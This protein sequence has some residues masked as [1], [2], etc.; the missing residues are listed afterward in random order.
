[1]IDGLTIH[2]A[3]MYASILVEGGVRRVDEIRK[4]RVSAALP[5]VSVDKCYKLLLPVPPIPSRTP[6]KKKNIRWASLR[7]LVEI[8]RLIAQNEFPYVL[9]VEEQR[10]FS[11]LVVE[12]RGHVIYLC[13]ESGVIYECGESL[14]PPLKVIERLDFFLNRMDRVT[15]ATDVF[16]VSGYKS[17]TRFGILLQG[18]DNAVDY[19]A[20]LT[21]L[22]GKTGLGGLKSRG[23]GKFTVHTAEL[24][25]IDMITEPRKPCGMVLLGSYMFTE[26]IDFTKSIVNK[27]V[28]AGYA[29]PVY[30]PHKLPY[31]DY[32][33]AGSIIFVNENLRP[34]VKSV[35]TSST[36]AEIVFNP[37]VAGVEI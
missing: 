20:E 8:T 13:I 14:K 7:A 34:I 21:S 2:R 29:G 17:Y 6:L 11:K 25:D 9:S 16:K 15:N 18:D 33:G 27:R 1:M 36:G 31:I 30:D 3:L 4:L 24:C 19:S 22:L 35:K 26:F 28:L 10:G 23:F 32:I 37:V 12:A 5:A